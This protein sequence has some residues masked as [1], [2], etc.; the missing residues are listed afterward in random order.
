MK[1]SVPLPP[2]I[3]CLATCPTCQH[4]DKPKQEDQARVAWDLL[5]VQFPG[6]VP[7]RPSEANKE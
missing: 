6:I 2:C 7:E 5:H 3:M 4:L 1:I